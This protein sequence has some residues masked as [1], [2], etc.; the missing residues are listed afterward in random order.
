MYNLCCTEEDN[1]SDLNDVSGLGDTSKIASKKTFAMSSI[2]IGC[3]LVE[4]RTAVK[5]YKSKR[6]IAIRN[7]RSK[8][9]DIPNTLSSENTDIL[10][11]IVDDFSKKTLSSSDG[12]D[13]INTPDLS[14]SV[15]P[16][17]DIR[18]VVIGL[19]KDDWPDI[20]HTLNTIR[21]LAIH[22]TSLVVASGQ[23]HAIVRGTI[24]QVNI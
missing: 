22:H 6:T 24:K 12:L 20:F 15:N 11:R 17:N 23:L 14:P 21:T 4:P 13:Y 18:R 5:S 19:E 1:I 10:P 7:N 8:S 9:D 3:D 2:N 16:S